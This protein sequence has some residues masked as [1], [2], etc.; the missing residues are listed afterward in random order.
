[1]FRSI[2]YHNDDFRQIQTKWHCAH[3]FDLPWIRLRQRRRPH[4]QEQI[5][6]QHKIEI[7]ASTDRGHRF[8]N[9]KE[10]HRGEA[11]ERDGGCESRLDRDFV[12]GD[13]PQPHVPRVVLLPSPRGLFREL[14][15][16][17]TLLE[18]GAPHLPNSWTRASLR[19]CEVERI[20]RRD[21]GTSCCGIYELGRTFGVSLL[22]HLI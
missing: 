2:C 6:T 16:V 3:K 19:T 22:L 5:E 21:L 7:R 15:G 12:R 13:H 14:G 17:P 9:A 18:R 4:E 1:M 11:H 20:G 10:S 8:E